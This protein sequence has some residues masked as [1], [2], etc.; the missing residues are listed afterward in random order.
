MIRRTF[1]FALALAALTATV[2]QGAAARSATCQPITEKQ[3]EALFDHW[4]AALATKDA[5][6]VADTYAP[7]ASL[8]PT[9]QNGPLVG[10]HA[11]E[12]YFEHF[13]TQSPAG[14]IDRRI[15][16]IG[17]NVAYDIGLYTFMVDGN[18]GERKPLHARY[19]FIYAPEHGRWMIVHHHS[20]MLPV[21]Q[22]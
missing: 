3:V 14:H 15:I 5:A 2:P 4:N 7:D 19:T 12:Q 22:P 9:V 16:R 17:C 10:R 11:I 21:P 20:S 13:V 1:G 18:P 8:L 6:K